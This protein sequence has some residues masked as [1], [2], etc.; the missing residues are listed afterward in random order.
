MCLAVVMRLVVG[1]DGTWLFGDAGFFG[2]AGL[3][4]AGVLLC[5][6]V[7]LSGAC[8]FFCFVIP[9]PVNEAH[10]LQ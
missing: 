8:C 1:W 7:M 10:T 6:G 2:G 9:C 4:N 5:S 3:W